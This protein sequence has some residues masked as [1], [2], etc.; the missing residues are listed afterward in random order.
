M[1]VGLTILKFTFKGVSRV[2]KTYQGSKVK[3]IGLYECGTPE[4]DIN[5]VI[6]YDAKNKLQTLT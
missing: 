6:K 3:K 1:H 5:R 2:I 4:A